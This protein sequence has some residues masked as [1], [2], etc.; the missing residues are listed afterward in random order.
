LHAGHDKPEEDQHGW[1]SGDQVVQSY[2]RAI[3]GFQREV[4]HRI[5]D[6]DR[7]RPIEADD[8]FASL[9]GVQVQLRRR[10]A[11]VTLVLQRAKRGADGFG[12][13]RSP[14]T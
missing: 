4:R 12:H 11:M 9:A 14:H 8:E 1:A 5:A 3:H 7:A 2:R 6:L 10:P 13:A